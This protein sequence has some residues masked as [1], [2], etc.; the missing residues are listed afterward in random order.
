MVRFIRKA[1]A[2]NDKFPQALQWSKE[3]AEYLN[4]NYPELS[5]Q[6]FMEGFGDFNTIY[7]IN[8]YENLAAIEAANTRLMADQ[9]YWMM[10]AKASELFID[11][12]GED[13]VLY[14]T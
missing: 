14:A 11:G 4:A 7:W 13:K 8:D 12:T 2:Q 9:E 10:L 1:R 5:L 3:V 6:V